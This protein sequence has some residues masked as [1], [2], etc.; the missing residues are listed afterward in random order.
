M[1]GESFIAKYG[2]R[3]I[4]YA[5]GIGFGVLLLLVAVGSCATTVE[6]TDVGI[7]VNNITGVKTEVINGGMVL[8]L[9]FGLSTVYKI[10]KS[11]RHMRLAKDVITHEHPEGEQVRIK[12]SDGT[13]VE[14][15]IDVIYQI[16]A[17]NAYIAFRE[18][19]ESE[20]SNMMTGRTLGSLGHDS[21]NNMES[22][23]RAVTRSEIRNQLGRLDTL[24]MSDPERRTKMLDTVWKDLQAYFKPMGVDIVSVNAQNFHFNEEYE[25]LIRQRKAADQT[26]TNQKDIRLAKLEIKKRM[27]AVAEKNKST[28]I[29]QLVGVLAQ[30]LLTAN[31]EAT[32]ILTKAKQEQYQLDKEGDI[33]LSTAKLEAEAI[34]KEGEQ[35]AKAIETLFEAYAT[36]GEGLVRESLVKLY[37]NV[38]IT[39]KPYSPSDRVDRIQA[40]PVQFD[41][42]RAN[43]ITP[44]SSTLK[45]G[46]NGR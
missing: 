4:S 24:N 5:V 16:D 32:R 38:T 11:P 10:S 8:H 42:P 21:A 18:L 22:I 35:K 29:A 2:M 12:T 13:N 30:K 15:D 23:L 3:T 45:G 44:N 39:A 25:A 41:A 37:E 43:P 6:N 34:K 17:N 7:V 46:T 36:G 9:P 27:M 31:G 26:L 19:E 1:A 33:A 40:V 14:A 20:A 28:A